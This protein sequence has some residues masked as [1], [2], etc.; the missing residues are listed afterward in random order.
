MKEIVLAICLLIISYTSGWTWTM[1][2]LKKGAGWYNDSGYSF[3]CEKYATSAIVQS[4]L[5]KE[6]KYCKQCNSD[7]GCMQ[8]AHKMLEDEWA[9][10]NIY[11]QNGGS[12]SQV[13]NPPAVKKKHMNT[14]QREQKIF[15][16]RVYQN[17]VQASQTW[18]NMLQNMRQIGIEENEQGNP[19]LYEVILKIESN[20]T[21]YYNC[22]TR[23]ASK[24]MAEQFNRP[25]DKMEQYMAANIESLF[26]RCNK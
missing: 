12:S 2:E 23:T 9:K 5:R 26:Y 19:I 6:S 25:Y 17:E 18:N 8:R 21:H 13:Y 1:D 14:K 7:F 24:D 16:D 4:C 3:Q 22:I 15:D 20:Y 10:Y 11:P